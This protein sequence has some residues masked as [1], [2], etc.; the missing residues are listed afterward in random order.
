TPICLYHIFRKNNGR[1]HCTHKVQLNHT[2]KVIHLQVKNSAI[3]SNSRSRHVTSCTINQHINGTIF[4]HNLLC[5]LL[6]YSLIGYISLEED[7][8]SPVCFHLI[9]EFLSFLFVS[10]HYSHLC[11]LCSQ[12]FHH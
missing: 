9:N 3:R 4:R 7:C 6:Q 10:R 2:A 12:V 11:T 1:H 8:L 5:I